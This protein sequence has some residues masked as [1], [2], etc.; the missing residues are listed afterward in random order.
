ME[1]ISKHKTV[2][3]KAFEPE[4][5]W[6]RVR[7]TEWKIYEIITES[8]W[9]DDGRPLKSGNL[10]C[11]H[12]EWIK[13]NGDSSYANIWNNIHTANDNRSVNRTIML[14]FSAVGSSNAFVYWRTKLSTV[15]ACYYDVKLISALQQTV[16]PDFSPIQSTLHEPSWKGTAHLV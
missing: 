4:H 6:A 12:L 14:S 13:F 11:G 15:Q 5:M 3:G 9:T 2:W 16:C 10:I 8:I 1:I 7:E